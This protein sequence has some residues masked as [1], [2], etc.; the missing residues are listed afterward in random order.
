M[1]NSF[2]RRVRTS[3]VARR[4][5]ALSDRFSSTIC[6]REQIFLGRRSFVASTRARRE[7]KDDRIAFSRRQRFVVE[8]SSSAK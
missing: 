2:L 5:R 8:I 6:T 7:M 3:S 1:G 4:F